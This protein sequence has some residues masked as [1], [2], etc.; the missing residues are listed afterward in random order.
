MAEG[1][2]YTYDLFISYARA[3]R[4]WV[5]GYLLDAMKAVGVRVHAEEA[6][7]LGVPRLTEFQDA[8]RCSQRTVLVLSP[9]YLTRDGFDQFFTLVAQIVDLETETSRIIPLVLRPVELPLSL[10]PHAPP[11]GLVEGAGLAP[12]AVLDATTPDRWPAVVERLCAELGCPLPGPSPRPACPYPGMVP[13][14]P[15]EARFFYGRENEI[16]DV[17]RRLRQR[18][19]LIVGPP[20]SGKSSLISAGLIPIA[21]ERQ[22]DYWLVREMRPGGDPLAG[23]VQTLAPH[24]PPGGPMEDAGPALQG[25]PQAEDWEGA[26]AALLAHNPPHQHLLLVIDQFEQVFAQ[27][28]REKWAPFFRAI[29][30]LRVARNC[31]LVLALRADFYPDLMASD[32]WPV[33]PDERLEIT[34]L[35]GHDLRDAIALPAERQGVYL[36]AGLLERLLVDAAEEPAVLP[37]VQETMRLLWQ[38]MERRLLPLSVYE[39]L[40]DPSTGEWQA[41]RSGLGVAIATLGDATWAALSPQGQTIARRIF[42]RLVQFGEG[43]ADTCRPQPVSALRTAGDD[44]ALFQETLKRLADNQL[45]TLSSQSPFRGKASEELAR[46][47]HT[48]GIPESVVPAQAIK[49]DLSGEILSSQIAEMSHEVLITEWPRLRNWVEQY[50][51]GEQTRRRLEARAEAWLQAG[52]GKGGLLEGVELLEAE[53]WLA[54]HPLPGG[55]MEGAGLAGPDASELGASETLL[56]LVRASRATQGEGARPSRPTGSL[57]EKLLAFGKVAVVVLII[58]AM[59]FGLWRAQQ[60]AARQAAMAEGE[61]Q[62]RQQAQEAAAT[63]QALA[64][65]EASARAEAELR[66]AEAVHARATTVAQLA[67][68]EATAQAEADARLETAAGPEATAEAYRLEATAAQT[69]AEAEEHNR[70][71][72][73]L[74]RQLAGQALGHLNDLDRALLLSLEAYRV[75]DEVESEPEINGLGDEIEFSRAE[76]KRSLLAALTSSPQVTTFLHGHTMQVNSL[77][78]SPVEGILASGSGDGTIMLWNV[79]TDPPEPIGAPLAGHDRGVVAVAFSPDTLA[80][81]GTGGRLLASGGDDGVVILWNVDTRQPVGEPLE[82][83]TGSVKSLAFSPADGRILASGGSD[84]TVILWDVE[85]GERIDTLRGHSDAVESV[86]FS[87]DTP[88]SRG[89]GGEIL[90]SAGRDGTI[91]LWNVDTGALVQELEGHS[92]GV[93]TLAFSPDAA[94]LASG[95]A[96]QTIRLWDVEAGQPRERGQPLGESLTGHTD[97]VT[98]LVFSPDGATLVSSSLDQTIILWDL[99]TRQ[100]LTGLA[101]GVGAMAFSPG[102]EVLA[103]GSKDSA[104]ILWDLRRELPAIARRLSGHDDAVKSV[105]FSPDTPASRRIGGEIL[106]S[107]SMDGSIRLWNAKTGEPVGDPLAGH[108]QPVNSVTFSPSGEL[109]ASGGDDQSIVLW[110][111]ETREPLGDPLKGHVGAVNSVAFDPEGRLLASGSADSTIILW[112]VK[113]REPIGEPLEGHSGPVES[114]AFSPND[115]EFLLS[116]GRGRLNIGLWDVRSG[117]AFTIT[118]V[119]GIDGALSV[120]FGPDPETP[121]FASGGADGRILLTTQGNERFLTGH[122]GGVNSLAFSP[123]TLASRG[124]G[125]TLLASGGADGW[126]ILWDVPTG[127]AIGRLASWAERAGPGGEVFSVA[128]SPDGNTLASGGEDKTII[129]WDLDLDSWHEQACRIANRNLTLEEWDRFIGPNTPYRRTCPDLPPGEGVGLDAAT[130]TD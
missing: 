53:R 119:H 48:R 84:A 15:G 39:W 90:A 42:L 22:P 94:I 77:A 1:T 116:G 78:F 66:Q 96:D 125:G 109:M 37:L 5:E 59:G 117:T 28:P 72:I 33:Y 80:S 41:G 47:T 87:P 70:A 10:A 4:A 50:R 112:D 93:Y 69:R 113:T 122:T 71:Q 3:D 126:V 88:A 45:L 52:G 104:I 54:P 60:D 115:D 82:G 63:A 9:A 64:D 110:D 62:Q 95:G 123:D 2:E 118:D 27:T 85:T 61:K 102:G 97:G 129:L 44:V 25:A 81:R 17:W 67:A 92:G 91:R 114:V 121:S 75:V 46:L 103:S 11:G 58:A 101:G 24:P 21:H 35:R 30:M 12:L 38:R 86:A 31:T 16:E 34:P 43:R 130:A 6:F 106:A 79:E 89:T 107:G 13:F 100:P 26:V 83:H 18:Y 29:R 124:T 55:P 65:A 19:V 99:E 98:G 49:G 51:E 120:A 14:T 7:R 73:A 56:A 23:L 128:F 108:D 20:G 40:G 57:R 32:L 111:V 8:V 105:A 36:E 76:L 127:Q 68:V 74:A